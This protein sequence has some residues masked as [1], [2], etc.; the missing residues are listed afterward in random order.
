MF[1]KTYLRKFESPRLLFRPML[2]SDSEIVVGWRNSPHVASK[3]RNSRT[4]LT[5]YEHIAWFRGS[6]SHRVDYILLTKTTMT[7]IGSVSFDTKKLLE[8]ELAAE[9]G[10]YIGDPSF[11]GKG[12]GKEMTDHWL[13]FG[14]RDLALH[15]IHAVVSKSNL[16]NIRLNLSVGFEVETEEPRFPVTDEFV[17]MSLSREAFERFRKA[18]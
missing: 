10:K 2:E 17:H 12:Y 11:L 5:I 8:N 14:F 15:K 7:P 6:R 1:D 3:S 4:D 13:D 9:L 16:I 18:R